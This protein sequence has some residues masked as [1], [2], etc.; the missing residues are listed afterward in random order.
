MGQSGRDLPLDEAGR[1]GGTGQGKGL[2]PW[3]DSLV[4]QEKKS[5][6]LL[7]LHLFSPN[8]LRGACW[9]PALG[10]AVPAFGAREVGKEIV[11]GARGMRATFPE[12]AELVS[13]RPPWATS[14]Q[15]HRAPALSVSFS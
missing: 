6:R 11:G 15:K 13:W 2:S 10:R 5:T 12:R 14:K 4:G 9:I 8:L 3:A 7:E 1:W